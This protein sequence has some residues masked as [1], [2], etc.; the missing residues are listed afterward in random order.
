M[1]TISLLRALFYSDFV[2]GSLFSEGGRKSSCGAE[3]KSLND[4]LKFNDAISL[5]LPN[6]R[7]KLFRSRTLSLFGS[8]STSMRG[9]R[10]PSGYQLHTT[11]ACFDGRG[12]FTA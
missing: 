8:S 6:K 9:G 7:L 11:R 3:W 1:A 4:Q 12:K 10:T 5:R 2:L